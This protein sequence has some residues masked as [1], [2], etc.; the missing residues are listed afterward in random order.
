MFW[1]SETKEEGC[2]IVY[3]CFPPFRRPKFITLKECFPLLS[4]VEEKSII[5]FNSELEK[6]FPSWKFYALS[7][8]KDSQTPL[9]THPFTEF[10][11]VFSFRCHFQELCS[12]SYSRNIVL[13]T[14]KADVWRYSKKAALLSHILQDCD[15]VLKIS[16]L[17]TSHTLIF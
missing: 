15:E 9:V 16:F 11:P 1:Y 13:V 6:V 4:F 8:R 7:G 12:T 10:L 14:Q 3:M 5:L 2:A 17:I